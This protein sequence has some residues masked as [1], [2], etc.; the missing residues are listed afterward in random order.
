[1]RIISREGGARYDSMGDSMRFV[2]TAADTDGQYSVI[3]DT[4]KPGF[5]AALH[6]HRTHNEAFYVIEGQVRFAVGGVETLA[7]P[8]TTV[9][10][11]PGVP[12]AARSEGPGKMLTVFSPGGLEGAMAAFGRMTAEE[13]GSPAATR[14]I[15]EQYDIVEL[16]EAPVPALVNLYHALLAGDIAAV[17][18]LFAGEPQIDTP[19]SGAVRG[20]AALRTFVREQQA[21]LGARQA[22][23]HVVGVIKAAERVVVELVLDL[24]RDGAAIDLPVV[25]A[26]DRAGEQVTAIRVYHSTWPLTGAHVVRAPLLPPPAVPPDEPA[27]IRAYMGALDGPDRVAMLAL[28]TEDG[29]VREPSGAQYRHAGPAGRRAFYDRAL[30][31]GGVRLHHRTA[32]FDGHS[33]AVEYVCD[34]WGAAELP[35]QAGMAVYELAGPDRLRAVR[36]YDDISPPLPER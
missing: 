14:A 33:F 11:P 17:L 18:A 1:M 15:L 10:V 22:R 3:E 2:L 25:L 5:H 13:A 16:A 12:H 6:L 23:P 20:E 29:Y 4:L 34:R 36:I 28:F 30:G 8:G 32:T 9:F 24:V 7:T 31:A 27:L 19:L 35:P 21:W 26:A